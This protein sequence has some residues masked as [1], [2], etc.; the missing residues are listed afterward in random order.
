MIRKNLLKPFTTFLC[1]SFFLLIMMGTAV[2]A[3]QWGNY[4]LYSTMNGTTTYLIDTNNVNFHTWT[5]TTTY[6]TC[7]SSYLVAG[8]TLVRTVGKSGNSFSG[9][10]I[11]GE[12][13]KVDW[14]GNVIW[15]YVYS[16]SQYC[17]H[18]DIHP[19]PNGNVLLIAY[20]R[21]TPAEVIAAGC[22]VFSGE[23]WPDKIVEVQ[24]AGTNGGN[25]VWEWHAWDHLVQNTNALAAN[26][27][28]SIV[29]HP[30]L[31][32][33]NYKTSKDWMHMNGVSYNPILDQITFSCH[34]LDELYVIDHSTTTA[35]A[36]GHT[37]GNSGKGGDILYRWGNPDAYDAAGT[38]IFD[39]VHDAHWVPE[40]SPNAGYLVGYNNKGISSNA[41][42]VDQIAPP[43]NGYNYSITLG[44][45]FAPATYTLR[46]S[47]G[48]YNSNMGNSQ[49]LPNG[50]MLL[51]VAT[52]GLIKEFDAAG[53]LL[54][55]KIA[56]GAVPKAYRYDSCYVVNAAPAI[57]TITQNADTL[58]S[59]AAVTYQWY[60]NGQLIAGATSQFYVAAQ[61]GNYIV[62]ITDA[63]GCVN[64]Y[65]VTYHYS[66]PTGLTEI[67][68]NSS[69]QIYPNP[70]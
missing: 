63:N 7:Y 56:T 41:S 68:N 6:K 35:Q 66:G 28:T 60:F 48:G 67:K 69:I 14:N 44:S 34:N 47:S 13:Q 24:P 27:Q 39:V 36:A 33:I 59:S 4:T 11:C 26:Y 19:M 12:V 61:I 64:Q 25:I 16:T 32:N 17:T 52:A 31:L 43:Y 55:S 42:C 50:N 37:G 1:T 18:H 30:E 58:F 46:Q 22:S 21:K 65:S 8:G 2:N 54:W 9:G 23:M 38:Q 29:D 45:A 40:G 62:R 53:T 57:P 49:Q 3:Q 5:T 15:D 70:T 51:C 10:P 20:E